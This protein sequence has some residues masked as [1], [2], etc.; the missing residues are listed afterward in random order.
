[1]SEQTTALV[2]ETRHPGHP[3]S[4]ERER[5]DGGVGRERER[6]RAR[7]KDINGRGVIEKRERDGGEAVF[8]ADI[9]Q[10]VP[11][12]TAMTSRQGEM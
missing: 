12:R 6:S 7:Q 1:M 4:K 8:S 11:L 2:P 9:Q 10:F 5:R 3:V